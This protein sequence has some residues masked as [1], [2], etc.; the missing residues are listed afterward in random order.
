MYS[1]STDLLLRFVDISAHRWGFPL[2]FG[3][4]DIQKIGR[5]WHWSDRLESACRHREALR[6]VN[7]SI[8]PLKVW[9]KKSSTLH[10]ATRLVRLPYRVCY[11][12]L[13]YNFSLRV[14]VSSRLLFR[15]MSLMTTRNSSAGPAATSEFLIVQQTRQSFPNLVA[16]KG[17]QYFDR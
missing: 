3:Q 1:L 14:I 11:M 5:S 15:A 13:Y 7:W 4:N 8:G 9:M 6:G 16:P 17:S 2:G 10:V 12:L